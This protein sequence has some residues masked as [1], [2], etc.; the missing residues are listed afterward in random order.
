VEEIDI[1]RTAKILVDA[2]GE[3][4]SLEAAMRADHALEDGLP[5]AVNVW[6][7]VKRAVEKLQ[8]GRQRDRE[9]TRE[10]NCVASYVS[11]TLK[12]RVRTYNKTSISA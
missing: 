12:A 5:E 4:A 8:R 11:V 2:H 6:M 9:L 7:R 3:N 10:S 1:W